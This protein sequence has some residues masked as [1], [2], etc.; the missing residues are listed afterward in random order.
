MLSSASPTLRPRCVLFRFVL[1]LF[2][3]FPLLFLQAGENRHPVHVVCI[4]RGAHAAYG[5]LLIHFASFSELSEVVTAADTVTSDEQRLL[6]G[7]VL[8]KWIFLMKAPEFVQG[9]FL[10]A[11]SLPSCLMLA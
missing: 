6:P 1:L 4:I 9:L 7:Q 11:V 10:W 3:S 8:L 5:A 2:A